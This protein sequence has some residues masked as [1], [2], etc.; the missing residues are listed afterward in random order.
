MR[1]KIK[2]KTEI[3]IELIE[4]KAGIEFCFELKMF[5]K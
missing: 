2:E 3:A 5:F 4:I 1:T